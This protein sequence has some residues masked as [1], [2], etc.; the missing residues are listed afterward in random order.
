MPKH[1]QL[2]YSFINAVTEH[3]K[4]V[5]GCSP[6]LESKLDLETIIFALENELLKCLVP[7]A[8]K[9]AVTRGVL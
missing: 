7:R 2:Q 6:H 8:I 9:E 1:D 4:S 5:H 3:P